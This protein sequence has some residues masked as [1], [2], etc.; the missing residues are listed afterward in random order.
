MKTLGN[1]FTKQFLTALCCASSLILF[2]QTPLKLGDVNIANQDLE[3]VMKSSMNGSEMVKFPTYVGDKLAG[4]KTISYKQMSEHFLEDLPAGVDLLN[5]W[6]QTDNVAFS[7]LVGDMTNKI[8][9]DPEMSKSFR[10]N[11]KNGVTGI[12]IGTPNIFIPLTGTP[13]QDIP[14]ECI[15]V[16]N[17]QFLGIVAPVVAA[18]AAGYAI[19][20]ALCGKDRCTIVK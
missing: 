10:V 16:A 7:Q 13:L 20:K 18:F 4:S 17:P 5:E 11:V 12:S 14:A 15:D 1:F 19:G 3:K 9:N 2:A 6:K 8:I